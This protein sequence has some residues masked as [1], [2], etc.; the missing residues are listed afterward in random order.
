M[1][2][3]NGCS[4][5]DLIECLPRI[6]AVIWLRGLICVVPKC[7]GGKQPGQYCVGNLAIDFYTSLLRSRQAMYGKLC[8]ISVFLKYHTCV[9]PRTVTNLLILM[10]LFW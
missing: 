3:C 5:E 6:V 9:N 2:K 7:G 8:W 4:G 10:S 1:L